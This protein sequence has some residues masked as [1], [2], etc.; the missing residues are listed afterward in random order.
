MFIKILIPFIFVLA[1]FAIVVSRRPAEFR[2]TR[3]ATMSALPSVVFSQVNDL[4]KWNTWSPWAKMDPNAQLSYAGPTAGT[5]ASFHWAGNRQIGEGTMTILDSKPSEFI[6]LKLE[7]MKPFVANNTAE[8]TFKPQGNQTVVTWSMVGQNN[9]ISK[10][11]GLFVDCD[12]MVGGQ[13]EKGLAT[14]KSIVES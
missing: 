1:I 13:F 8:F 12:K 10:A 6:Q 11:I 9:F 7:F 5:G 2:V 14:L 4:H 3:S